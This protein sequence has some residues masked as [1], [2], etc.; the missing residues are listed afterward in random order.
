MQSPMRPSQFETVSI[1]PTLHKSS[2]FQFYQA[3]AQSYKQGF[4]SR[5]ESSYKSSYSQFVTQAVWPNLLFP[6]TFPGI[7][8]NPHHL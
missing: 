5:F 4:R 1:S 2:S 7:L 3:H 6:I 8:L